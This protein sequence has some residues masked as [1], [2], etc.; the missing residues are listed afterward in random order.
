MNLEKARNALKGL[1]ISL[2]AFLLLTIVFSF[3]QPAEPVSHNP[4]GLNMTI[5]GLELARTPGE[6]YGIIGFQGSPKGDMYR[7][8][9]IN[10]VWL[11]NL[12][13][14]PAYSASYFFLGLLLFMIGRVRKWLFIALC[15]SIFS[16]AILDFL[17]NWQLLIILK[18]LP[19][20]SLFSH[21]KTLNFFAHAKFIFL[22]LSGALVAGGLWADGRRGPAFMLAGT[23]AFSIAGIYE[24]RAI[25]ISGLLMAVSWALIFVKVLPLKSRWWG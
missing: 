25:E 9:F 5:I 13:Y 20:A 15:I 14:I 18:P 12:G 21:L 2:G 23:L 6:L 16:A 17:E 19:E 3:V 8:Q 4:G 11:D 7:D 22:G 24:R 10:G 1:Q